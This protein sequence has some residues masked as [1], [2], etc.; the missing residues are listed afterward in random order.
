[1]R[2]MIPVVLLLVGGAALWLGV[3][4]PRQEPQQRAEPAEP[5]KN[6]LL[7]TM[8]TTRADYLGCYGRPDA[9]TPNIDKLAA[10]GTRF[11]R[12]TACTPQTLPSHCTIL[13]STY[14]YVHGIRR[15]GVARLGDENVTL[16]EMFHEAG[17]ATK[18]IIGSVVLNSMHGLAQGFDEYVDVRPGKTQNPAAAERKAGEVGD[19]AASAL[20]QLAGGAA[21]APAA[22]ACRPFFLWVHFYD[23]HFPYES[24]RHADE[25]SPAAYADEIAAMDAQIGRLMTALR[26]LGR[27]RDTLVVLV[28]DHGEGLGQHGESQHGYFLY[29][30]TQHVPLIVWGLGA[31]TGSEAVAAQVRTVDV[32]PT[33]LDCLGLPK[34]PLAQGISLR[35]MIGR[36]VTSQDRPAYSETMLPSEEFGFC[37]LRALSQGGWKYILA[38]RP[39]LYD[40]KTDSEE[41]HNLADQRADVAARMRE[42]LRAVLAEAP[43]SPDARPE[44]VRLSTEEARKLA[45]LG[46]LG[47]TGGEDEEQQGESAADE[48]A[49]FEPQGDSPAD[50]VQT[51]ELLLKGHRLFALEK[52]AEAEPIM[53]SVLEVRPESPQ[54]W[55]EWARSMTKLGREGEVLETCDQILAKHPK[56]KQA[57]LFY[58]RRLA[59]ARQGDKALEVLR[60]GTVLLA[61]D[62][63]M[64]R[65]LADA[66]M[67]MQ[68]FGEAQ[69]S[70]EQAIGLDP[71][72][73]KALLGMGRLCARTGRFTEAEKSLRDAIAIEP[74][75][76]VLQRE[77]DN[78][79]KSMAEEGG[80]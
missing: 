23:P 22:Q 44:T 26:D 6:V 79:L 37:R 63:E 24:S 60:T 77:L 50:H 32:M 14:P 2:W 78:V 45:A 72:D 36:S 69:S 58:A 62:G 64:H 16:A 51:I 49:T 61:D 41:Q 65:E 75:W 5:L 12:C 35:P 59:R 70:Y 28:G 8:D 29:E 10:E 71:H 21:G 27:A 34:S 1:M 38:T 25:N 3:L 13:T 4:R 15:N 33:I 17:F 11:E 43:T 54:L 73:A 46:Y 80:S 48:L 74:D 31:E 9:A 20:Q 19:L 68:R 52:Y 67:A 30:T 7:I 47:A 57:R 39:E 66:L 53:R 40:L 55:I 76:R 42:E 56:A 18:A